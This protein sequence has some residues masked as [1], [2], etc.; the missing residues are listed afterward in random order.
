LF[1][2]HR[3]DHTVLPAKIERQAINFFYNK[4]ANTPSYTADFRARG[5]LLFNE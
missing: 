3:F 5:V 1:Q 4:S 2:L